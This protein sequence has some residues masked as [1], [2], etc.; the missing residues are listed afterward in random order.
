MENQDSLSPPKPTSPQKWP[1]MKMYLDKVSDTQFK[2][3]V[4]NMFQQLS[5]EGYI[6]VKV[7]YCS[8]IVT[9]DIIDMNL[10]GTIKPTV[11]IKKSMLYNALFV[12]RAL[13]HHY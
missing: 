3:I 7:A 12:P 10:S 2:R 8:V 13:T 4:I 1:P 9:I 11:L 6:F 5:Q